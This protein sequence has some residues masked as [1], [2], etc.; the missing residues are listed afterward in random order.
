MRIGY[1]KWD[2]RTELDDCAR[3]IP[4]RVYTRVAARKIRVAR[5]VLFANVPGA[6]QS[7]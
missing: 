6:Q 7:A 2:I 3:T 5:P 1:L 4:Q